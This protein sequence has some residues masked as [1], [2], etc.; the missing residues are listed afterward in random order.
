MYVDKERAVKLI[1]YMKNTNKEWIHNGSKSRVG[2]ATDPRARFSFQKFLQDNNLFE[3]TMERNGDTW[4]ACPFH[5]DA[6]P[7]CSI[8]EE[9]YV[10]HC[11]SCGSRGNLINLI[12]EYKSRYENSGMGYYQ[13]L[14]GILNTDQVAQAELG[15][16]SIYVNDS[17]FTD[18]NASQSILDGTASR[19]IFKADKGRYMPTS[20]CELADF[21]I[22]NHADLKQIKLFVILMQNNIPPK[23]IFNE[24]FSNT[25]TE[26]LKEEIDL[27]KLLN[28]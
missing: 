8:N 19:F 16:T 22:K 26:E 24:I 28:F 23:E 20:Y 18:S 15:F 12:S 21:L 1:E 4:I 9:K 7:S 25:A 2:A 11:F 14:N 13:I 3:D 10:Y 6:S 17:S 5:E 27:Q